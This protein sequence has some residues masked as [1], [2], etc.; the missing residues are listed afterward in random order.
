MSPSSGLP[1]NRVRLSPGPVPTPVPGGTSSQHPTV[2]SV[3]VDGLRYVDEKLE[4]LVLAPAPK[5]LRGERVVKALFKHPY[6]FM[7]QDEQALKFFYQLPENAVFE[8]LESGQCAVV[9][10]VTTSHGEIAVKLS[11]FKPGMSM[12]SLVRTAFTLEKGEI[13][14]LTIPDHPNIVKT[15]A[16]LLLNEKTGRYRLVRQLDDMP[17][18]N[19]KDYEV[20]ASVHELAKGSDLM[21][22]IGVETFQP[23]VKLTCAVGIQVCDALTHLHGNNLIYR[24]LKPENIMFDEADYSIRL[25]DMGF[26]KKLPK[27]E[28]TA[29]MC[30]TPQYLAPELVKGRTYNHRVDHWGLGIVLWELSTGKRVYEEDPLNPQCILKFA[31]KSAAEKMALLC[32]DHRETGHG[33]FELLN[34]TIVGLLENEAEQRMTLETAKKTLEQLQTSVQ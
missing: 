8:K 3:N 2:Q 26:L 7:S 11:K 23:N 28:T 17:G 16:L 27:D 29:T 15:Y 1:Q 9:K 24:D 34:K 18:S 21:N 13:L 10:K 32:R 4:H 14:G 22:F 12:Q 25:V 5:I 19:R 31:V 30:G 6:P 33:G 20:R